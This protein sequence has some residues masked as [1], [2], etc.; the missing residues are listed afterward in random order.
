MEAKLRQMEQSKIVSASSVHPFL[1]AK[2]ASGFSSMVGRAK[3]HRSQTPSFAL[4]Y[5]QGMQGRESDRGSKTS[6]VPDG[7]EF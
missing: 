7:E 3:S 1:P 2:P 6:A 4:E 5:P